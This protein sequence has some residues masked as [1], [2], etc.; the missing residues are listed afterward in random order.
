MEADGCVVL[1]VADAGSHDYRGSCM[2][3][4]ILRFELTPREFE[5]VCQVLAQRPWVE[6]NNILQKMVAQANKSRG[7]EPDKEPQA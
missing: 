7:E 6:V 4:E 5:L 2:T 1:E 3:D